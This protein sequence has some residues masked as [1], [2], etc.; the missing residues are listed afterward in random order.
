MHRRSFLVAMA[1]LAAARQALSQPARPRIGVIVIPLLPNPMTQALERGLRELGYAPGRN[2]D[3]DYRSVEGRPERL[4]ADARELVQLHPDVIVAGGGAPAVK[5][6]LNA[7]ST[8]PIVFPASGDPVGEGLV[9][10]LARPGGNATGLSILSIELSAKR[11]QL[12]RELLP[13]LRSVAILQDLAM[14]TTMDQVSATQE[15]GAKL[16]MRLH[17]LSVESPEHYEAA[18]EAAKKAGAE[19]LIVL[20]SSAFNASRRQLIRLAAQHRLPTLWEHKLFTESGGLLSYGTDIP[21]LYRRA[22]VYVDRI[23]KGAKP[24]DMPVERATKVELVINAKTAKTLGITV[25]PTLL[26]RADEVIQ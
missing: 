1:T 13:S 24:A 7:T 9:N 4:P 18:F 8:I 15:A 17:V 11:L 12:L 16:A 25:A 10:S 3:I 23:L 22:A 2:I 19:A 6:A 20:P 5:A 21:D 26:A 14:R